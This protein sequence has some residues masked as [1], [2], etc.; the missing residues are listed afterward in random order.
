MEHTKTKLQNMYKT[1]KDSFGY[2]NPMAVP[3]LTKLIISVGTG[4]KLKN[5]RNRN[6]LVLDRIAKITGQKPALRKAKRR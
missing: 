3:K 2:T 1:L 4:S 5:D 6:E